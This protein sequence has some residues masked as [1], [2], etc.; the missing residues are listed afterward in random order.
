MRRFSD[1]MC[2]NCRVAT[3]VL[4]VRIQDVTACVIDVWVCACVQLFSAVGPKYYRLVHTC[5]G[6]IDR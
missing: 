4:N 6:L 5:R 1:V 2:I 3:C